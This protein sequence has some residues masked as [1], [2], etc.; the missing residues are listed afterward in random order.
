MAKNKEVGEMMVVVNEESEKTE[1]VK[2]V[3]A[4]DEAVA[5][6]SANQANAIKQECEEALEEAMPALND[7]LKAG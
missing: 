4:A 7:A 2:E 3:V 1:K 6:E 5:S